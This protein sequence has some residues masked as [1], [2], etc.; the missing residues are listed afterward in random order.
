MQT[1][2]ANSIYRIGGL[3]EVFTI[4]T[5]LIEAGD[6]IWN[7][8]VT[9]YVPELRE[10]VQGK[11][12]NDIGDVDWQS[13]TV[14]QLASHMSGISRDCKLAQLSTIELYLT[15]LLQLV[16]LGDLGQQM[17][18]AVAYGFPGLPTDTIPSCYSQSKCSRAG[19]PIQSLSMRTLD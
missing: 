8:P 17:Q 15:V 1:V 12:S 14:G 7:D 18:N 11:G 6:G 10:A 9:K 3:T 5:V 13:I 4:W 16:G 19:K 2:D